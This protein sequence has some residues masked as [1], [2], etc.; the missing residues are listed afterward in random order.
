[1]IGR[2]EMKENIWIKDKQKGEMVLKKDMERKK[3]VIKYQGNKMRIKEKD[4]MRFLLENGEYKK[5]EEKKVK[6]DK[7]K[8]REEKKYI[9]RIK[10]YR[11][12]KGMDEEIVKGIGKIEGMKIVE[13]VKDLR[14][15]GGQIGMGDGEEI[16]KGFEKEIEMKRKLVM[17]EY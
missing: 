5:I 13:K 9:D 3:L 2:S 10:D 17:L 1:M 12:R 6:I 16:I 15:M 7:M 11:R 8:F 4:R 14:L